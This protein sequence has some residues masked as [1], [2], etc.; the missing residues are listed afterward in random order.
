MTC[1]SNVSLMARA[2]PSWPG[3]APPG[4]ALSR[5]SL[6][7]VAGGFDDQR[8][9]EAVGAGGPLRIVADA[10][11][12][13]TTL[14]QVRRQQ[15]SWQRE[16]SIAMASGDVATGV[17]AYLDHGAVETVEGRDATLAR[18]ISAWT[19]LRQRHGE[20][21][22]L[23]TR[24][25]RDAVDLNRSARAILKAENRIAIEE[26]AFASTDREG[27][28]VPIQVSTGDLL[29]FGQ[30]NPALGLRNGSILKVEAVSQNGGDTRVVF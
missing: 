1:R 2:L 20:D 23:I 15:I 19:E 30:T 14:A 3:F 13:E 7:S 8:Q 18:S 29:R 17:Q 26:T 9:L 24:R 10:L 28:T 16:A 4:L 5:R 6:R 22:L 21:V 27:K 12:R 11:E 25:N